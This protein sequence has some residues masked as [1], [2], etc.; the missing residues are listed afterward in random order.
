MQTGLVGATP[1]LLAV[2]SWPVAR[3]RFLTDRDVAEGSAVAVLGQSVVDALFLPGEDPI[4]RY[5]LANTIPFQ[6]IGVMARKGATTSGWDQDEV[7]FAPVTSAAYR[8][9]G[10]RFVR[11]IL[12]LVEDGSRLAATMRDVRSLLIAR[13]RTEDF[14]VRSMIEA[15]ESAEATAN[16]FTL[17]MGAIAAIS[18]LVGGIGV[19][20]IM[21]VGVA[22]R[23]R[24]IGIR[25]A[26]GAR[27]GDIAGQFLVEAALVSGLG[28]L[29]G[30]ALG[31]GVAFA[32][33]ALGTPAVLL[34]GPILIAFGAAV[35]VGLVFGVAPARKAAALDPVAALASD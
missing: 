20:N 30:V 10:Q 6:V 25:M 24:E 5:V 3:G 33:P 22:E 16:N 7:I 28:G 17:L 35:L 32:L 27:R 9:T 1:D 19:M 13:H 4:G 34:P 15:I 21:L 12:L 18:L 14:S 26:V 8:V 31:I 29:A 23:R 11:D 2:R